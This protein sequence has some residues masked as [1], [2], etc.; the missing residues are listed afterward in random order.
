MVMTTPVGKIIEIRRVP[1]VPGVFV[2]RSVNM[3][4]F[5]VISVVADRLEQGNVANGVKDPLDGVPTLR[6]GL[7]RRVFR[8]VA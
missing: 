2:R 3:C 5:G 7:G 8:F 1:F 4:C 6:A